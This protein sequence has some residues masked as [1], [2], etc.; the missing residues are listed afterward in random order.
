MTEQTDR[1]KA[2][3]SAIA[4]F[5]DGRRE[6]KLKGK[7]D[8][9]DI[10]SKYDYATWLADAARRVGQIQAVTHVLKATHP[11]AR[12]TS[13]HVKPETLHPH[14]EIGSHTLAEELRDWMPGYRWHAS[15]GA[16]PLRKTESTA[17]APGNTIVLAWAGW[18]LFP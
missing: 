4:A 14:A 12:G 8:D 17:K 11:D 13:L 3:R 9:A 7:E 10:A 1:G 16:T 2:F 15:T 6:A 18:C 5:I